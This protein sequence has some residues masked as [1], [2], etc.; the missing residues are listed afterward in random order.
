MSEILSQ[1]NFITFSLQILQQSVTRSH[2]NSDRRCVFRRINAENL[3]AIE[4]HLLVWAQY[5]LKK[6][7]FEIHYFCTCLSKQMQNDCTTH[8]TRIICKQMN[9]EHNIPKTA[10]SDEDRLLFSRLNINVGLLDEYGWLTT[11]SEKYQ[12]GQSHF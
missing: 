12:T 9:E 10:W 6:T 2:A 7:C 4:A 1:I 8:M 3:N 11:T 5:L